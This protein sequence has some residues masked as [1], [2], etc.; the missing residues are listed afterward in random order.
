MSTGEPAC[1]VDLEPTLASD[2]HE[3]ARAYEI[4]AYLS[5]AS[6][7][8]DI[9]DGP[10]ANPIS[11]TDVALNALVQHGVH[12]M[13]CDRAFLSFIDNRS[14]FICAE[15]TRHQSILNASPERPLLLGTTRIPLEWGV[16]PYTMSVFHGKKVILPESPH[17]VADELYFCIKDFREV[18]SFA[19]RPYVEGYPR[20]VSYIEVPLRSISG[21]IVGSYCVV[22][23][24]PRDFLRPDALRTIQEAA[25]AISQ[26]LDL[27][28]TEQGRLRSERMMNGLC[29]FVRSDDHRPSEKAHA[30]SPF[31]LGIFQNASRPE[32]DLRPNENVESDRLPNS[33]PR[34][35]LGTTPVTL[36]ATT[37][38]PRKGNN[39]KG[40]RQSLSAQISNLLPQVADLIGHAMNLDGF[41]FFDKVETGTRY[42][43]SRPSFGFTD[44]EFAPPSPEDLESPAQPLSTFQA[45]GMVEP[46]MVCW[47]SQ[48]FM[49]QLTATY[50]HGHLFTID[51]YGVF[52]EGAQEA[53]NRPGSSA[54]STAHDD[55]KSLFNCIPKA[56]YA[57]FLPLWHYQRESS[58]LTCLAWV[59]DP[60]K[61]LETNDIDSLTAFGNSLMAEIF[62]LEVATG[63]QQKSDF[64]S[65]ISHELRS[66]IHG[67]LATVQ[68]MQDSLQGSRL[69]SMTH[70]IESCSNTLLGTFDH[71]LEFSKINSLKGG[72]HS[73]TRAKS[74]TNKPH[75]QELAIDLSSLVEDVL[76]AVVLGH[77]SSS[78]IESGLKKEHQVPLDTGAEALSLPALITTHIDHTIDWTLYTDPGAWK[79]ILLNIL[80]NAVRFTASGYI[81]VTLGM[82]EDTGVGRR[83]INLSVADNGV[84][85]SREFLKYHLF[86]PF[87]QEN[88]FVSGSGLGLSIVKNIVESLDG[89]I[90][91]E[92]RQYEGTRVIVNIPYDK[93]LD[94]S[95]GPAAAEIATSSD[96]FLN[97]TLG[98]VSIASGTTPSSTTPR[99]TTP[100]K[101]LQRCLRS[102][103]E[104]CFGMTVFDD[105]PLAAL[106]EKDVVLLD[107]HALQSTDMLNLQ[108]H[109]PELMSAIASRPVVVLGSTTGGVEQFFRR[110]GAAFIS[111]P[112][113]RKSLRDAVTTALN[114]V[115]AIEAP[116][117][118]S[119]SI[120]PP[121]PLRQVDSGF[122][123]MPRIANRLSESQ[124]DPVDLPIRTAP[125]GAHSDTRDDS[126]PNPTLRQP[127]PPHPLHPNPA[128]SS[129][130]P[131]TYRFTRLLLVDDNPI[132]LKVLV[133]F[134]RK[135]GL[136]YSTAY[137]GAE[138]LRLYKEAATQGGNP[139]D[140]VF[141]DI[142]MP[143]MDGFQ[144]TAAIRQFEAQQRDVHQHCVPDAHGEQA[145]GESSSSQQAAVPVRALSSYIVAL[146]GLGSEE[147]RRMAQDSG[148][149]LFLVKPINLKSLEPLL[150]A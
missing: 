83:C 42:I 111:S 67:I 59:S 48:S 133:A 131:S 136:P 17:I 35:N 110:E 97:V 38:S 91:V 46:Q 88:S 53:E 95:G 36:E 30:T 52:E 107:T 102:I 143:V 121:A 105:L 117:I 100:P 119:P 139:Y 28:R 120:H 135:T 106:L 23:D 40:T 62:R 115:V 39:A 92:S 74:D 129:N 8:F 10:S 55:E 77:V 78:Q 22:D 72:T 54:T 137:D 7:P 18:P 86:T 26:Y 34:N 71:L 25:L 148:F 60:R 103:C 142:T 118:Q 43:G 70:M 14:Q 144:A 99:I 127:S 134:I 20:M 89:T 113:T 82:S 73:T 128:D 93:D 69:L 11:S 12:A 108:Q 49:Q 61:T 29:K 5:A 146:T 145:S 98:L 41:V 84:G 56:R 58:F 90:L 45:D 124:I 147:A 132:N 57:I 96:R 1:V 79:R 9:E 65:S 24:K 81:E 21:H 50:P 37:V 130:P 140:C 13:E 114:R 16:C 64:I 15:M 66:P 19:D 44:E 3:R 51:E 80:S 138:A 87:M 31:S 27:K 47:P 104:T 141:M 6:F 32:S 94:M 109:F 112:I 75:S 149:D 85:M 123:E 63:T 150:K 116:R 4:A 76:Q 68:L 125:H 2:A 126:S 122:S 33:L 101:L